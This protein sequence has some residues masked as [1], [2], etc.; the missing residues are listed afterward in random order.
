MAKRYRYGL[1]VVLLCGL[2]SSGQGWSS[3]LDPL[4]HH[5]QET[6]DHIQTLSADFTQVATLT[7]INREQTSA[8]RV[9]V[10][11][12]H[13]IRWE[14]S[15]PEAQTILYKDNLLRIYTPKLRQVMQSV[16]E[17]DNRAN[18]ALLF[19]A[20]VGTLREVFTITPLPSQ[21]TNTQQLRLLPRSPQASFTELHITV[22]LQSYL[23]ESLTIYD[24][25]G[26]QTA[27]HLSALQINPTLPDRLF[28]LD[29]PPG[30]EVL[31]PADLS[32][33]K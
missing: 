21:G 10:H 33:R 11:K 2:G 17:A 15:Q 5:I 20:G 1:L 3:D 26:N 30:T 18:V 16:V 23:I 31:T 25:I 32:E 13:A 28:A 12:P 24:P 9:Y 6:Y 8:G 14:Y 7:S 19:L 27:I 29:L 22:N 4:L